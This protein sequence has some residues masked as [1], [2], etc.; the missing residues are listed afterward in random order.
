[1]AALLSGCA[2]HGV[3]DSTDELPIHSDLPLWT[4]DDDI[5]PQRASGS[6]VGCEHPVPLGDWRYVL[7]EGDDS[8]ALW[9][10]FSRSS[11]IHCRLTEQRSYA[12]SSLDDAAGTIGVF[13]EVGPTGIKG[14]DR[15]LWI[16]QSGVRPGSDYL[17]LARK[18][19]DPKV[20]EVLQST[21]PVASIR[22]G[23]AVDIAR[24][25]YCSIKS[26]SELVTLARRAA[27]LPAIGTL[28]FVEGV[29]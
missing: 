13:I 7:G 28:S 29:P 9:I 24:T 11:F 2:H 21:C 16:L 23:P 12:K 1:M 14:D 15:M 22:S 20:F 6:D 3:V 4:N 5:W 18:S 17:L 19:S 8:N 25:D 26:K 27:A 10:R